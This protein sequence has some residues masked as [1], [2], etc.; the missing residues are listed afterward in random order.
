MFKVASVESAADGGMID[1][2]LSD[3]AAMQARLSPP[4]VGGVRR[5][6]GDSAWQ[7]NIPGRSCEGRAAAFERV[8]VRVHG[9][10]G[11]RPR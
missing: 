9:T 6:V 7:M 10:E 3:R 5:N 11:Q 2:T 4:A 1:G 8:T